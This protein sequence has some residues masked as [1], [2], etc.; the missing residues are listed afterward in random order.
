MMSPERLELL[1]FLA[2]RNVCDGILY[3][4]RIYSQVFDFSTAG[5][6][7]PQFSSEDIFK[8]GEQYPVRITHILAIIKDNTGGAGTS[9]ER[10]I[11]SYSLRIRSNDTYYMNG[12]TPVPIPLWAN[13][14][15]SGPEVTSRSTSSW[16]FA[17]PFFMGD[18]D[19]MSVQV[20]LDVPIGFTEVSQDVW[21]QFNGFGALSRRPKE[22]AGFCQFTVTS[23]TLLTIPDGF[24][25]ND[26]TEPLEI[27]SMDVYVPPARLV[28]SGGSTLG[29]I[30]RARISVR[31]VGNGTNQTWTS[32]DALNVDTVPT[33][34]FGLTTG[35]AMAHVLPIQVDQR[36]RGWIWEPNQGLQLEVTG[37][38]SGI[39][40]LS[41]LYIALAGEIIVK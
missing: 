14:V 19:T 29:N 16:R 18:R 9:D 23:P 38:L 34:L 15:T 1:K 39:T 22:L 13:V 30:R 12:N 35:R 31:Q 11:Q 20:Q 36:G 5:T 8:N 2:A 27:H 24:F 21:V 7:S 10:A 28:Q 25:R 17:H 3:E 40:E 37:P 6:L 33:G 32:S 26:G 4:P 41:Q